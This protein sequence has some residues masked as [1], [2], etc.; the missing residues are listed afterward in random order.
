MNM[1]RQ[2]TRGKI[3]K[4]F[5]HKHKKFKMNSKRHKQSQCSEARTGLYALFYEFLLAVVQR[6]FEPA[7]DARTATD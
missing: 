5:K 4:V 2:V 7:A 3:V 6:H 1:L